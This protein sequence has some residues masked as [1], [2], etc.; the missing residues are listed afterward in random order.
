MRYIA[1]LF[2]VGCG[3]ED[4]VDDVGPYQ[5]PI[6]QE[7]RDCPKATAFGALPDTMRCAITRAD[8]V[9][10]GRVNAIRLVTDSPVDNE[11]RPVSGC[12][13]V[14]PSL[15]VT[16]YVTYS[17]KGVAIE[18]PMTIRIGPTQLEKYR[19]FPIEFNGELRWAI[20][21]DFGYGE[22]GGAIEIGNGLGVLVH[23]I[24]DRWTALD[25]PLFF[26]QEER[27]VVQKYLRRCWH[28]GFADAERYMLSDLV[29]EEAGDCPYVPMNEVGYWNPICDM[30]ATE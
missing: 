2:V 11:G 29:V 18:G 4:L 24:A 10:Y 1:V 22:L 5:V 17:L 15:D 30:P 25:E 13:A 14:A 20:Y 16:I 6:I 19:P 8:D 3:G 12:D 23:R 21:S 9:V 7:I 28:D 27:I 26:V